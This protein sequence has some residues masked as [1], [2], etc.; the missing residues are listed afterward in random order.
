MGDPIL[1]RSPETVGREWAEDRWNRVYP[2]RHDLPFVRPSDSTAD[3]ARLDRE[4]AERLAR[5]YGLR[6][7]TVDRILMAANTQW[8]VMQRRG[9]YGPFDRWRGRWAGR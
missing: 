6:S 1:P 3:Y 2:W 7:D 9:G 4:H 8:L 5:T